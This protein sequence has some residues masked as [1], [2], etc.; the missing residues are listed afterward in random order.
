MQRT[1]GGEFVSSCPERKLH[2]GTLLV[3]KY[4]WPP[5]WGGGG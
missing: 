4:F 3:E 5:R 1:L 2:L